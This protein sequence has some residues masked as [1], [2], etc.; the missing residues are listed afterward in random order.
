[1]QQQELRELPEFTGIVFYGT[2]PPFKVD[3]RSGHTDARLRSMEHLPPVAP[4]VDEREHLTTPH[5]QRVLTLP[6]E[7]HANVGPD[8]GPADLA[9]VGDADADEDDA[10]PEE[11]EPEG[12]AADDAMPDMEGGPDE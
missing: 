8:A 1:V 4:G 10:M 7:L 2:T 6:A 11:W 3:W 9:N 5:E 12:W